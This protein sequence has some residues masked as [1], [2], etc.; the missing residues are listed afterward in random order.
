MSLRSA[1]YFV[2]ARVCLA[3]SLIFFGIG[4]LAVA[5]Y[6]THKVTATANYGLPKWLA[7][8]IVLSVG[9]GWAA[10]GVWFTLQKRQA[11]HQGQKS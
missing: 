8:V 1:G 4:G 3:V 9:L 5:S 6:F 10:G 11:S 7:I 2:L